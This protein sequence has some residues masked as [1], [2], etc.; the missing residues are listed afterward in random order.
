MT[1]VTLGKSWVRES[2]PLQSQMPGL[3]DHDPLHALLNRESQAHAATH[4]GVAS[5][6]RDPHAARDLDHRRRKSS[7][8][9]CS[10]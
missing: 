9:R 8:T 3:L 5:G 6:D 7:R 10:A 1:R 2:R 4:V